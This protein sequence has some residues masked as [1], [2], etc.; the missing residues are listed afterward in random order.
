MPS[1]RLIENAS[2]RAE[3]QEP[4]QADCSAAGL[5]RTATGDSGPPTV[6]IRTHG[7]KLNQSDS[8]TIARSFIQAG[9]RM[10]DWADGA[11]VMVLNTCTI[12]ATADAKARQALRGA[13]HN[14]AGLTTTKG[15]L[16]VATGCYAQ[17]A[18]DQ[19]AKVEGISLVVGN[20]G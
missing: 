17:R 11:D 19:L 16:V 6:A 10:V 15:P 2:S 12:T 4:G 8:E 13:R 20:T 18:A 3:T 7:C 1:N 14:S 9:Y 5:N